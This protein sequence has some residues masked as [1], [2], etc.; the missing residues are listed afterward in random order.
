M[1]D[2]K[3]LVELPDQ[4]EQINQQKMEYEKLMKADSE[5]GLALQSMVAAVHDIKGVNEKNEQEA[6]RKYKIIWLRITWGSK[7]MHIW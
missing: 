3:E 5:A 4:K 1:G 6:L 7:A 2:N